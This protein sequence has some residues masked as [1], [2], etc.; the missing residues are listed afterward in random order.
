MIYIICPVY[1]GERYLGEALD[2][3]VCQTYADWRLVIVNDGSTDNTPQTLQVFA[4]SEP[5]RC[6]LLEQPHEGGL[7]AHN[8]AFGFI[9]RCEEVEAVAFI[10]ADDT[11]QPD[12]LA[13][14]VEILREAATWG[15]GHAGVLFRT[16]TERVSPA[17]VGEQGPER[18]A[19]AREIGRVV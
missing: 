16:V 19:K 5:E 11:W 4:E 8:H 14:Q 10:D 17:L 15:K 9:K 13:R 18:L 7:S 6:L 3:V 2:S 1:N 12:K